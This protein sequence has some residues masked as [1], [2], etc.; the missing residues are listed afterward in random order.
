M[1]ASQLEILPKIEERKNLEK[2]R[3]LIAVF[4]IFTIVPSFVF[5]FLANLK[6]GEVKILN[7]L[8]EWHIPAV[9]LP[10]KFGE[11]NLSLKLSEWAAKELK[12]LP[13]EWAVNI[14]IVDEDFAWG[15]NDRT[16]FVAASIIKLPVVA[17][18]YRQVELGKLKLTDSYILKEIDK[19]SGAGSLQY[20]QEG[21]KLTLAELASLAL[22]QSDNT[23]YGVLKKLVGDNVINKLIVDEGMLETNLEEN[24]ISAADA[25]SFFLKLYKGEL[26]NEEFTKKMINDL[27]NTAFEDRIPAGVPE[28]IKVAHKVGTEIGVFSDS[29]IVFT[30]KRTIILTIL[31][32]ETDVAVA[33][34]KFPGLVND[35]YWLMEED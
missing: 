23:A 5:W 33:K 4:L 29:G 1:K 31:S 10:I 8:I 13:G 21:A 12:V 9:N 18:F 35:V 32:Q 11:K 2:G 3:V 17:A 27:T 24:L 15:I 34:E 16:Q 19:I 6:K 25:T 22:S 14:K 26:L 20:R 30:P 7:P 28:G